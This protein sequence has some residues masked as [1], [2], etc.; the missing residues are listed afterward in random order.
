MTKRM[1]WRTGQ[2][3]LL[4]IETE[5]GNF[6]PYNTSKDHFL[7]DYDIPRGTK[8]YATMQSLLSKGWS[9]VNENSVKRGA[10]ETFREKV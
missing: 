2:Y 8:G 9:L 5:E 7:K 6:I 4:Y 3:P 1:F 10:R